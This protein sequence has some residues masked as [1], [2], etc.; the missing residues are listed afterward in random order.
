MNHT[1]SWSWAYSTNSNKISLCHSFYIHHT[2]HTLEH[3]TAFP[4]E[5]HRLCTFESLASSFLTL[6]CRSWSPCFTCHQL[7]SRIL[8]KW[9]HIEVVNLNMY[10][11][12]QDLFT[13]THAK[14][15]IP[16]NNIITSDDHDSNASWRIQVHVWHSHSS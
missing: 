2:I 9:L 16:N 3:T 15:K 6:A 8:T 12:F 14:K 5:Y 13:F 10:T 1:L 7:E 11:N 4:L